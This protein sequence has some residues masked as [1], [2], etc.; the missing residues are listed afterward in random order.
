MEI[1][2][3]AAYEDINK[4]I[5]KLLQAAYDKKLSAFVHLPP[6]T[7]SRSLSD[8]IWSIR[9]FLPHGCYDEELIWDREHHPI[10]I[11]HSY[12]AESPTDIYIGCGLGLE[13]VGKNFKKA[14][15]AFDAKNYNH[16]S[17]LEDIKKWGDLPIACWK[18]ESNGKWIDSTAK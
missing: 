14:L 10:W 1:A 4:V 3:Y 6:N 11:D 8:A 17:Y 12:E 15:I 2:Y 13:N 5:V 18:Q 7:P 16:N 9:G